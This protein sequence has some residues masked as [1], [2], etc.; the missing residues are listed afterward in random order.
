MP[1]KATSIPKGNE[2]IQKVKAKVLTN[3]EFSG[4][5]QKV[6]GALQ[7]EFGI[8]DRESFKA[9]TVLSG[10]FRRG[11]T[12]GA[13]IGGLMGL[14]LVIGRE[15]ME[16]TDTYQQAMLISG[17]IINRFKEELQKQF[18]LRQELKSTLCKEVQERVLGRS[19]NLPDE[20]EAFSQAGG[21]SD[22]GCPKVCSIAAQVVAE[23]ILELKEAKIKHPV[24]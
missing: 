15:R 11:E 13:L 22:M 7:E 18:D 10:G 24:K 20:S 3:G 8:G 14:G 4:C 21:H 19:F 16:D 9:A 17:E 23:K 1:K 12:C 6:L 5:S 2:I